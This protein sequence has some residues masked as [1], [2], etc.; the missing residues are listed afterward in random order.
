MIILDIPQGAITVASAIL[1]AAAAG[2]VTFGVF[3]LRLLLSIRTG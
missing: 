1:V 2:F 3:V